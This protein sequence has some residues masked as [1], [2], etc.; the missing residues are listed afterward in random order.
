[1]SDILHRLHEETHAATAL[2][3]QLRTLIGD[4]DEMQ[5]TAIEGET[6]LIEAIEA[7][8]GR[9][10]ELEAMLKSIDYMTN[11]LSQRYSRFEAQQKNIR[12]AL[13]VAMESAGIK[14]HECGLGTLSLKAVPPKVEIIDEV[15]IPARFWKPQ[16]PKLDKAAVLKALK[17]GET[18]IGAMMSNGGTTIQVKF[19]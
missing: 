13:A 12:T 4:D 18:V 10:A 3:E 11:H 14:R 16:D 7:G 17:D 15:A 19:L 1:M 8:F 2:I 5:A 9:I 6:N